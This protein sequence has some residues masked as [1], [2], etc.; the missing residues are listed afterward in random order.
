M[1]LYSIAVPA[2]LRTTARLLGAICTALQ[3]IHTCERGRART[4]TVTD[5]TEEPHLRWKAERRQ[6][7]GR[8]IAVAGEAEWL[9]RWHWLGARGAGR[10][11][12]YGRATAT[13]TASA[14]G[15]ER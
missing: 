14:S 10:S 9:A 11:G 8:A 1:I 3:E 12:S 6:A 4:S 7:A 2:L 5:N 13:A 15:A